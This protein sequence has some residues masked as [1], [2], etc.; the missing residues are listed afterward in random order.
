MEGRRD[1]QRGLVCVLFLATVASMC[2]CFR[3]PFPAPTRLAF[4]EYRHSSHPHILQVIT[5][6]ASRSPARGWV[7]HVLS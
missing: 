5:H 4:K 3:T 6:R 2:L 7:S 1:M